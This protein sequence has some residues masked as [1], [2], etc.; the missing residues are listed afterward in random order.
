MKIKLD[1]NKIIGYFI[2]RNERFLAI[3]SERDWKALIVCFLVI[4]LV[5]LVAGGYL[6]W[7]IQFSEQSASISFEN[8]IELMK[9]E[10]S[11]ILKR[12]LLDLFLNEITEKEKRFNENLINPPVIKDPSI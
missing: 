2:Y 9:E 11:F 12:D 4:L 6:F 7:K 5:I 10:K 1:F 3:K 8:E